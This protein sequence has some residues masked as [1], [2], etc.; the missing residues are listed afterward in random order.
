MKSNLIMLLTLLLITSCSSVKKNNKI[1]AEAM[2][3]GQDTVNLSFEEGP[4][5]IIY[6]TKEDYK[7]FVPVILS[8]DKSEIISYPHPGDVYYEEK[9]AYP[10][11]LKKG[12]LLDNRGINENVAFLK[13]TYEDYSN[14]KAAPPKDLMY[15]MILDKDPLVKIFN[16]GNRNRFKNGTSDINKF[17]K[18][19][20]LKNCKCLSE[21]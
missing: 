20:G 11:E 17:I 3:M 8:K 12:Y 5:T 21:K 1:N 15:S 10:T 18:N 14:L 13:I 2:K 6:K 19:N 16:C 4:Q 7:T 9:L